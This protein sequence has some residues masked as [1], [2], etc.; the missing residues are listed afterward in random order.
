MRKLRRSRQQRKGQNVDDDA[1]LYGVWVCERER[2]RECERERDRSVGGVWM[3]VLGWA[4][5]M[6]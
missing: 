6:M 1:M 4:M 2:E 3:D 5:V